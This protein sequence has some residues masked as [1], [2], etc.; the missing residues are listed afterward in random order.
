MGLALARRAPASGGGGGGGRES[1]RPS[2]AGHHGH[3]ECESKLP[4]LRARQ[5]H[6]DHRTLA[7]V[8]VIIIDDEK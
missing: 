1:E 5:I 7:A 2:Q 8:L 4:A 3:P 6:H